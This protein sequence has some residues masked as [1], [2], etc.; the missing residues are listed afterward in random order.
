MLAPVFSA[1]V[2]LATAPLMAATTFLCL[3][4]EAVKQLLSKNA[5]DSSIEGLKAAGVDTKSYI[6]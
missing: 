3:S 4:I 2:G 1:T 6:P 5:Y